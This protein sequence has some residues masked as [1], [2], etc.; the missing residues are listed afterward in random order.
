[1]RRC[2]LAAAATAALAAPCD[3]FAQHG[4]PCAAAH[5]TTRALFSAFA[6][7]LYQLQRSS[8][9]ATLDIGV[10][11]AGGTADAASHDR[12]CAGGPAPPPPP[13][14][15]P[16]GL[17]PLN[18]VVRLQPAALPSLAFRHCYSQGFVTPAGDSGSDHAFRLLP[19]LSGAAGAYSFQS[20]NF[21]AQYIAPMAGDRGR[22]GIVEA[23]AAADA[24]WRLAPVAGGFSITSLA[25]GVGS[26]VVG[27]NLSGT[28]AH[29]YSAP[30]ASA[31]L[32][33]APSAWVIAPEGA[34]PYPPRADCVILKIYDQS[35][36]GNHLLPATPAINNQNYD[37]PV[38]AS[39]H[40]ITVGGKKAYS[41]YFESGMGYRAQNTSQVARGNDPETLYM[42]TSGTHTNAGC[43]FDYVR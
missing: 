27:A 25:P 20:A 32:G 5:A 33:Q 35:G 6:G 39:R 14:P 29:S 18:T 38:N 43:C 36:N 15:P 31:Y 4:T 34:G 26:L 11:N 23:P 8:D 10:L 42:V 12:F 22:A 7:A 21:P 1:M 9:N 28:C 41:A 13:P 17:P 2:L 40:P 3:L 37:N 16:P 19:A 24:S 30:S